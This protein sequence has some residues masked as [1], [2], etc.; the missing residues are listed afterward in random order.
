MYLFI[1]VEIISKSVELFVPVVFI[2]VLG[3]KL[4]IHR[5]TKYQLYAM[6]TRILS[7]KWL[8]GQQ[9]SYVLPQESNHLQ[10]KF[11]LNQF[12]SLAAKAQLTDRVIFE[13]IITEWIIIHLSPFSS[14]FQN[15]FLSLIIILYFTKILYTYLNE[16]RRSI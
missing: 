16:N 9:A 2:R 14:Y 4:L 15:L 13:C 3:L 5:Y 6:N 7:H 11:H 12:N 8:P 10:S 1:V